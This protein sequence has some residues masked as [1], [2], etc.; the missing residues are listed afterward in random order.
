MSEYNRYINIANIVYVIFYTK[1]LKPDM[2]F[3]LTHV[4]SEYQK[5][6]YLHVASDY[7]TGWN[8]YKT[9][10]TNDF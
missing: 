3:M 6:Q 2:H 8:S 5:V 1:F 4:K 10:K 9:G 7:Y